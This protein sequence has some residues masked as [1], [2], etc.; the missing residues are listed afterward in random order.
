[1]LVERSSTQVRRTYCGCWD[2]PSLLSAPSPVE[3][4]SLL[5]VIRNNVYRLGSKSALLSL[6]GGVASKGS[7]LASNGQSSKAPVS[8]KGA[9]MAK[10]LKMFNSRRK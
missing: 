4:S 3:R 7:V 2:C 5:A 6:P 9:L 1:M 10:T 8:K